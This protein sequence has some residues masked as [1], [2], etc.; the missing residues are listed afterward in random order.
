MFQEIC[1]QKRHVEDNVRIVAVSFEM[2]K[3]VTMPR[4]QLNT[5]QS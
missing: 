1:I 4:N 3:R 2:L 5:V